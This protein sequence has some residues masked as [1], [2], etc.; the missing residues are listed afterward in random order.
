MTTEIDAV[1]N[2]FV[3]EED[4]E[5][6]D[7]DDDPVKIIMDLFKPV[8]TRIEALD[9]YY[10]RE[11]VGDNAIEVLSSLA[12]MYQMSGSKLIEQFLYHICT[13]SNISAFLKLEVAKSLL[14]YEELEDESDNDEDE[15]TRKARVD[16]NNNTR[17]RNH[18]RKILGFKALNCVCN[19]LLDT[20]TPCRIEA[21][22]KL[23]ES[24]EFQ[25]NANSYF[26]I[27]VCDDSIECE[28]RYKTI[29]SLENRGAD[30]MKE[31][32]R[33]LFTD[34][35]FVIGF[36]KSLELVI[37]KLF[38]SVK[39]NENNLRLWNDV[40]Y[41]LGYDDIHDIYMKKFPEKQCFVDLFINN[42][43]LAFLFHDSNQTYYRT[44]AGQYLLQKC[45]INE[46]IR[47]Q[48]E[49][50]ILEFAQDKELDYNRRADAADILLRLGSS[51]MKNH[52]RNIITEL[53]GTHGIVRTV[54]D[55]AQNV[56]TEEVE[57]SVTEALEFLST[58]PLHQVNGKSIDFDYVNNQVEEMLKKER[59]SL[60]TG[61]ESNERCHHCEN[62]IEETDVNTFDDKKFC[63]DKCM[64]LYRRDGKIRLAM[65][66]I[67]MDRAMYSKFNSSLVNILLKVYTYISAREDENIKEQMIK[68][69]LEE[70]EEMSGTCS[71][72]FATRLINVISGFGQFNIRISYEDQI[73]A[74]FSGRLNAF[75]R[76]IT[77]PTS[78]FRLEK[79]NEVIELW[80]NC[81]EN[82]EKRDD[83]ESKLN[84]SGKIEKRPDIKDIINHFLQ[85]DRDVK[86]EQCIEDFAEAVLNEMMMSSSG[87]AER[88][89]FSLFFRSYVSII[90]EDLANEF[91]DL[92][93]D[94]DFD[95]FFRKSI[96]IYE[97]EL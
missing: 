89:N 92:I 13:D 57:E 50:Q 65:N 16:L 21:I 4:Y 75:A 45:K 22:C 27:F 70:L 74:N 68:R 9:N 40:L 26:C 93:S 86:V 90:R 49:K 34:K 39:R 88:Q 15:E 10:T 67:F 28:Y 76:K 7:D 41:R 5:D 97:G 19:N 69:L 95:L 66:R 8:K 77:D 62:P 17:Q 96:M 51:S 44:L 6:D 46:Q 85:E 63:S 42:A 38:P 3:L 29:L 79:L 1:I 37:N 14:D 61:V 94:T 31:E 64:C 91:K 35:E 60:N 24:A 58:I 78:I 87:Y 80:L 36:Y 71:S 81:P 47:F 55:N 32:I 30:F 56:H 54:F 84:P 11:N 2:S 20:P 25:D 72:G 83:I 33:C 23:M 73:V 12:G 18:E 52:G 82:K 43:Q 53:A 59:K 48:V